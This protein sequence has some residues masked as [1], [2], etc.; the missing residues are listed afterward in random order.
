MK[1]LILALTVAINLVATA[2]LAAPTPSG[3]LSSFAGAVATPSPT[4]FC[5]IGIVDQTKDPSSMYFNGVVPASVGDVVT[6]LLF[7]SFATANSAT[8]NGIQPTGWGNLASGSSITKTVDIAGAWS[9][10]VTTAGCPV[11][12]VSVQSH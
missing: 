5:E 4:P 6:A 7:T 2:L 10:V 3:N 1:R 12:S 8:V 9:F 11:N